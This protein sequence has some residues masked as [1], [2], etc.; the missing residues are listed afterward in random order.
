MES[1]YNYKIYDYSLVG[2]PKKRVFYR[3]VFSIWEFNIYY[4]GKSEIDI[5]TEYVEMLKR[6][7]VKGRIYKNDPN[8]YFE[9]E[10]ITPNYRFLFNEKG[11][12]KYEEI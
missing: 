6:Q 5:A 12:K 9:W 2:I 7:D 4:N 10:I 3:Y 8:Y 11:L 1:K